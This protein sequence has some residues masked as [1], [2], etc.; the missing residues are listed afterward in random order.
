MNH[1]ADDMTT[2]VLLADDHP[3][4]REGLALALSVLPDV[5][6]V[7]EAGDGQT[8]VALAGDLAPDVVMM[9]LNMPGMSGIEATRRICAARPATAVLVLTMLDGDDTIFAAMRAG[10]RG[11]LLKGADRAEIGRALTTVAGGD[12]VFSATIASRVL[13]WF[14]AAGS[15]PPVPFPELT[16]REREILDLVAQGLTNAAIAATLVVSPKTV[17]NHVSN[18]FT[19]LQVADRAEA[20]ARARDAGLGQPPS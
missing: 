1:G 9:D 18:V 13:A 3:L 16:T 14:A 2:T 20:V 11:Y 10:A 4:Y 8:A 15:T 6:V 17:R 12:V 19:K 5:E 7:A